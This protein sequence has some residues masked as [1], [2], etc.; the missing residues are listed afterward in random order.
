M[1]LRERA[2]Y[3]VFVFFLFVISAL[4][5]INS[6]HLYISTFLLIL[7]GNIGPIGSQKNVGQ[8]KITL[9]NLNNI[10]LKITTK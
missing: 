9:I 6:C 8:L 10:K 1:C 7:E 3:F 2:F 5:C 4:R